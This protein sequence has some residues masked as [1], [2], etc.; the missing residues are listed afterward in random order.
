MKKITFI[1]LIVTSS[2]SIFSQDFWDINFEDWYYGEQRVFIDTIS[3]QNNI[4]QIGQPS[5]VL[6]NQA[7]SIPNA[8]VTDTLNYYP[9]NDTSSFIITHVRYMGQHSIVIVLGFKYKINSDTIFDFGKI[10]TSFD[11]G[12]TW[13]DLLD[14]ENIDLYDLYWTNG[15]PILTGNIDSWQNTYVNLAHIDNFYD[16]R[17][18]ILYKFTFI[19]D[20]VNNQKEGWMIDNIHLEDWFEGI[21]KIQEKFNSNI[22]PNPIFDKG[23]LRFEN[24]E[25]KNSIIEIFD[26]YGKIIKLFETYSNEITIQNNDFSKGIYFYRIR[27]LG[28]ISFGKFIIN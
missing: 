8:I 19:S 28:G 4:W 6:F 9:T 17:D 15:K 13:I 26:T 21:D 7:Y 12:E 24:P 20:E 2:L 3:N 5:K 18:T 25:Y 10:E 23:V 27:N 1:I 11:L 16:Y 22:N 14:E